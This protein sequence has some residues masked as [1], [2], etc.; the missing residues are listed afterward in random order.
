MKEIKLTQGKI[1]LVDNEDYEFLMQFKWY[2]RFDKKGN[3]F[4]AVRSLKING[5]QTTILMHRVIMGVIDSKIHIDH[6]N[7]NT[8]YNCK[9]NLR[10]AT[11]SQNQ[12]NRRSQ[13]NSTSKYKGISWHKRDNNWQVSI[14]KDK[15]TFHI[16]GFEN[17]ADAA[18]AY[19]KKALELFGEFANLNKIAS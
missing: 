4:Y 15:K 6:V 8:L 9:S 14:Q 2:A 11:T 12:A 3:Y 16:G 19:N 10:V 13:K 7:H 1:A 18:L 5:K 17:E